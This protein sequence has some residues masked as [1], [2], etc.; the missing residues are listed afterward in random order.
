MHY[1]YKVKNGV[2]IL[3]KYINKIWKTHVYMSMINSSLNVIKLNNE[4]KK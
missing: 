3:T 1:R 2:G 4:N